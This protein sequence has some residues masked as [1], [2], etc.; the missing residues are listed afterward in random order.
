[1]GAA[2]G[3]GMHGQRVELEEHL[4]INAELPY[5]QRFL[6][7]KDLQPFILPHMKQ[8]FMPPSGAPS[9]VC[10]GARAVIIRRADAGRQGCLPRDRG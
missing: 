8:P 1:M 9:L 6:A 5:I 3:T 2:F 4:T 10:L 7:A